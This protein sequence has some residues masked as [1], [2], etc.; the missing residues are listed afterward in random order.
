[1]GWLDLFYLVESGL[2]G[3][4][5]LLG[6]ADTVDFGGVSD[7]SGVE[8]HQGHLL[9][10]GG[11]VGGVVDGRVED[12]LGKDVLPLGHEGL[13]SLNKVVGGGQGVEGG[14]GSRGGAAER[15]VDAEGGVQVGGVL[16]SRAGSSHGHQAQNNGERFHFD[17][18]F[19]LGTE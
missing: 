13:A 19:L 11:L 14:H 4:K 17:G 9:G 18:W 15:V 12:G 8:S 3:Q 5:V 2:E 6:L 7:G 16:G 10:F 1:M